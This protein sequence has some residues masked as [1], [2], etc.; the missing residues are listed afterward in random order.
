MFVS[1]IIPHYNDQ[2]RLSLC[3]DALE[4]QSYPLKEFEIIVIDNGSSSELCFIRNLFPQVIFDK[5]EKP[6]SY[7]ARNKGINLSKGNILAFLELN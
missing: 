3:L 2:E 1:V 7:A 6:G 5:E 4:Q